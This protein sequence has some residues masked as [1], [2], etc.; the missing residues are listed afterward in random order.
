M[1]GALDTAWDQLPEFTLTSD[2]EIPI[3]LIHHGPGAEDYEILCDFEAF[4]KANQKSFLAR[5]V[6][7][8]WAGRKDFERYLFARHLRVAFSDQFETLRNVH[9]QEMERSSWSLPSVGDVLLWGL[10]LTSSAVGGLL[11]WI[12]TETG[13]SALSRIGGIIRSSMVGRALRGK[14]AE[15]Q[16]EDLIEEKKQ[17][18]D[19]GLARLEVTLH[20]DLYDYAW[21]GQPPG[22]MTGMDRGAW[23]LPDFVRE[24]MG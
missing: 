11:L 1:R 4:M 12:A 14:S 15:E 22:P 18:V 19:E 2:V 9:R 13:R 6:L 17:V 20:R 5:P 3:Y 16:L 21:R 8:V 23:P 7:R 24:R 10:T